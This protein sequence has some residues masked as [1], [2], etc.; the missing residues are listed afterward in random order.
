MFIGF[1]F[2][3]SGVCLGEHI[4]PWR[5]SLCPGLQPCNLSQTA[6]LGAVPPACWCGSKCNHSKR[7]SRED[8]L[9]SLW[10]FQVLP[11]AVLGTCPETAATQLISPSYLHNKDIV[12][13]VL[14][15]QPHSV[16]LVWLHCNILRNVLRARSQME[17]VQIV[18]WVNLRDEGLTTPDSEALWVVNS[19]WKTQIFSL[20]AL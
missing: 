14:A 9:N 17:Y 18:P 4:Y 2:R 20:V 7:A 3:D 11:P 10:L 15:H 16:V 6:D 12:Y 1:I 19:S 13:L 8:I 5:L